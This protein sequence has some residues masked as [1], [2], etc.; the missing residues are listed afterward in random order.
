MS[1]IMDLVAPSMDAPKDFGACGKCAA[2]GTNSKGP[3]AHSPGCTAEGAACQFCA[4]DKTKLHSQSCPVRAAIVASESWLNL[5]T[6]DDG[7]KEYQAKAFSAPGYLAATDG[8]R[9]HLAPDPAQ[10]DYAPNCPPVLQVIPKGSGVSIDGKA[11]KKALALAV[12]GFDRDGHRAP[13]VVFEPRENALQVRPVTAGAVLLVD[14]V[15]PKKRSDRCYLP[16][17]VGDV[18][19]DLAAYGMVVSR[20]SRDR[21]TQFNGQYLLD[22]LG[23]DPGEIRW[24]QEDATSPLKITHADGRIAVVMPVRL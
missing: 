4:G 8:H 17:V 7:V 15:K 2:V 24:Y 1:D 23:K 21:Q 5:A 3:G 11:L 13:L 6:L 19:A 22:A 14:G 20:F 10:K 18:S 12:K 16:N 9:M